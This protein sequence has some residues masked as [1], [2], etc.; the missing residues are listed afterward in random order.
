VGA[1]LHWRHSWST[2]L[3]CI[4]LFGVQ[5]MVNITIVLGFL[6]YCYLGYAVLCFMWVD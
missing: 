4:F 2:V 3:S 6:L 5:F 1:N